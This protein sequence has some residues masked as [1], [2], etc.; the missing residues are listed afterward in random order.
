MADNLEIEKIKID[1][2]KSTSNLFMAVLAGQLTLTGSIFRESPY[3]PLAATS[4]FLALLSAI[5][6]LSLAEGAIRRISKPPQF[7]SKIMSKFISLFSHS[8]EGDFIKSI[9]VA[10]LFSS[11]ILLYLYFTLKTLNI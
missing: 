11:S 7:K 10:I 6:V 4:M 3:I 5:L 9:I 2:A 1:Y 8:T